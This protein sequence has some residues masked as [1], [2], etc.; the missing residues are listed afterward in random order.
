MLDKHVDPHA[1]LQT[2]GHPTY[3]TIAEG[4]Q[5]GHRVIDHNSSYARG[6]VHT[7]TIE[8]AFSLLK[9]GIYGT[10]RADA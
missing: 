10:W 9:R 6:D 1:T 8:S 4:R 7:N 2:D 3:A 5:G